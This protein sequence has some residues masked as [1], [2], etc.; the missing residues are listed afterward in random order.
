MVSTRWQFKGR[1]YFC[2]GHSG[3]VSTFPHGTIYFLLLTRALTADGN[4]RSFWK[5]VLRDAM[6]SVVSSCC[7]SSFRWAA[8]G[9]PS[10]STLHICQRHA[11]RQVFRLTWTH[12]KGLSGWHSC[13]EQGPEA[14][15]VLGHDSRTATAPGE[16]RDTVPSK[17]SLLEPQWFKP[18]WRW[19]RR[20]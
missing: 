19:N 16:L 17:F 20:R 11:S 15:H 9:V 10:Y 4:S 18:K 13:Q 14:E 8:V 2:T 12:T 6:W 7:C 1:H 3:F 5:S